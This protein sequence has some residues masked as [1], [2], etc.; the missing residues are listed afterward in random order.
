MRRFAWIILISC[1]ALPAT[2]AQTAELEGF[3]PIKFGMTKEEAWAAIEGKG[4]W[5]S[6]EQLTYGFEWDAIGKTF[7]V[8]QHFVD[9]KAAVLAVNLTSDEFY[10]R[11]CVSDSLRIVATIKEKYKKTPL[12]RLQNRDKMFERVF[13]TDSYFFGFGNDSSIEVTLWFWTDSND[14][15]LTV[16]YRPPSAEPLPF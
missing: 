16:W 11:T 14:C 12:V 10:F 2:A 9:G 4:K 5:K 13:V 8:V 1:F 7:E 6:E 15:E 3:G